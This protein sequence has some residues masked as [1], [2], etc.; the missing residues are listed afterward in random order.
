MARLPEP[1]GDTGQWGDVLNDYLRVVHNDDGSLKTGVVSTS[2]LQ[3]NC[4]GVAKIATSSAPTSGQALTFNGADLAWSTVS[5]SGSAPD[6]TVSTKG[7]VQLTGDLS[8][9]AASPTVPGLANKEAIVVAGTTA[10]YY[11]GDKSWQTLNKS[12]VGLTNVDNT[13][14]ASKPVSTAT[15]TALDAKAP[16]VHA[17]A[18]SDITSGTLASARIPLATTTT[19]GAVQLAGDLGGTADSPTVPG[20]SLKESTIA[21]GTTAQYYR[22]DKSWQTLDKAAAGLGNV[23]NTSDANKPVS[24]ATQTALTS[25]EG[26]ITAGT[27]AQYYRGDKSWQTLDKTAAGL[28]NVDNT[29]D[30]NKPVSSATQTALNAKAN[31]SHVHAAADITSGTI[32][33]AR[34]PITSETATGVVQLATSAEAIAGTDASKAV[35]PAGLKAAVTAVSHPILFVDSLGNIPPG[36]PVDTLVIVRAA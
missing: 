26:V 28:A 29:S 10:Q 8:G 25:K 12:V 14:D 22:G 13:S 30:A 2:S 36:T 18:A 24:T 15:Q 5:G 4:I 21:A 35:T 17:H 9:S 16:T 1:G 6:A 19:T 34:L 32:A 7:V 31:T 20:L 11:R 33:S 27:T 3:D 23:D